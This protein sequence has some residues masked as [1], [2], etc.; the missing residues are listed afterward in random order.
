MPSF[1]TAPD[2]KPI[3]G[4]TVNKIVIDDTKK[5]ISQLLPDWNSSQDPNKNE[6]FKNAYLLSTMLPEL[7]FSIKQYSPLTLNP[8]TNEK[9]HEFNKTGQKTKTPKNKYDDDAET[10]LNKLDTLLCEYYRM[11]KLCYNCLLRVIE[12]YMINSTLA[13]LRTDAK[14]LIKQSLVLANHDSD[15]QELVKTLPLA[16]DSDVSSFCKDADLFDTDY[17]KDLYSLDKVS[18]PEFN[19]IIKLKDKGLNLSRTNFIVFT[20]INLSGNQVDNPPTPPYVN[21]NQLLL[22]IDKNDDDSIRNELLNLINDLQTKNYNFYKD[23]KIPSNRGD[24]TIE[25]IKSKPEFQNAIS[26]KDF[27]IKLYDIITKTNAST[28]I[29]TLE[30]TD[31][32]KNITYDKK[33]C[34][35]TDSKVFKLFNQK[36][37]NTTKPFIPLSDNLNPMDLVLVKQK[38]FKYKNKYLE[39][40]ENLR[41]RQ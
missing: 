37:S 14:K 31:A 28:L 4:S 20:V 24:V 39:L 10:E 13:G 11:R 27:S 17:Y 21:V 26:R 30:A 19:I 16:V 2:K 36:S 32:L 38:Y 33:I 5:T 15:S 23:L 9:A 25:E 22:A 8:S 41:N 12:G 18:N 35:E 1:G 29:G 3:P 34:R 40:K 6:K 7:G